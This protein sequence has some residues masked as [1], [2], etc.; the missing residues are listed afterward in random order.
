MAAKDAS[1]ALAAN[2]AL[3]SA[4]ALSAAGEC[5]GGLAVGELEGL[6]GLWAGKLGAWGGGVADDW[7]DDGLQARPRPSSCECRSAACWPS[8]RAC[9]RRT[10][11]I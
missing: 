7:T 2:F 6:L 9:A 3:F 10:R 5:G 1:N 11:C 4:R 8:C